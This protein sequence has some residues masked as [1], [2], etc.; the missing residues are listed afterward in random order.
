[1]ISGF[2]FFS[3]L[4]FFRFGGAEEKVE[5]SCEVLRRSPGSGPKIRSSRYRAPSCK[6]K[7]MASEQ[8]PLLGAEVGSPNA[9]KRSTRGGERERD[10]F[11]MLSALDSQ[12]E[13]KRKP[14]SSQGSDRSLAQNGKLVYNIS[15][16]GQL[17]TKVRRSFVL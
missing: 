7:L 9:T 17:W 11:G 12:G 13:K 3:F 5:R 2:C 1:M 15:L 10:A 4:F 16:K 14:R 8:A 6:S